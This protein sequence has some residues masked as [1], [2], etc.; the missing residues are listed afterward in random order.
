[1]KILKYFQPSKPSRKSRKIT[2]FCEGS[3]VA[4]H[5]SRN[6][7]KLKKKQNG[8]HQSPM[9]HAPIHSS[10]PVRDGWGGCLAYSRHSPFV[11]HHFS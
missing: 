5:K 6:L 8:G 9:S 10:Q 7:M 11:A 2:Y 1:M 4:K 3:Q